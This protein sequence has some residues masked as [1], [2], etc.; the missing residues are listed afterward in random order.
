MDEV[1]LQKTLTLHEYRLKQSENDIHQIGQKLEVGINDLNHNLKDGL[2]KI[3]T[4]VDDELK[5]IRRGLVAT[6]LSF[7]MLTASVVGLLVR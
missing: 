5:W 6:T 3:D 2:D 4:K 7:L 1:Q